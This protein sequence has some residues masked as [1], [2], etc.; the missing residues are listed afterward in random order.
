M[1]TLSWTLLGGAPGEGGYFLAFNRDER[2]TRAA[3]LAPRVIEQGGVRALAPID[4]EA[5]G[6]WIAVN[7]MGLSLSIL[8]GYRFQGAEPEASRTWTSRG[9]LVLELC[10][11][12][13]LEELSRRIAAVRL[14]DYRPF[15]LACFDSRGRAGLSTWD[16]R[17]LSFRELHAADRPLVSS[18]FDDEGARGQRRALFARSVTGRGGER[19][20]ERFHASHEPSRGAYSPCMHREDAHTVS[21]TRVRV[22]AQAVTLQ[23]SPG[24]P[25]LAAPGV[26]QELQRRVYLRST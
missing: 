16:G 15:E 14:Q 19:E 18:A 4:G 24:S 11:A 26:K 21:F 9:R 12:A 1:C 8:N 20:L 3:G 13:N 5:G 25:C 17:R 6:T 10:D 7:E 2:R 23:T 22:T